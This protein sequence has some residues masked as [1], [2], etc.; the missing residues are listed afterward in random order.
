M[1]WR[2][3]LLRHLGPGVLG[4]VTLR[5]W[6]GLLRDNRFALS[7]GCLPRAMVVSHQSIWNS[8]LGWYEKWRY[9]SRVEGLEFTRLVCG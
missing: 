8:A 6:L 1:A 2:D 4:G 3:R 9:G 5:H 7:P